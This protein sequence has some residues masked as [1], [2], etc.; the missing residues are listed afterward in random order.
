[1]AKRT[2]DLPLLAQADNDDVLNIV[3]VS[4]N[5]SK[6]V[7]ASDVVPDSSITEGKIADGG[8]TPEKRSGG[9]AVGSLTISSTGNISK[10]GL[11]FKPRLVRV[12]Y[13]E[14]HDSRSQLSQG[15]MD[16][17]GN[18]YAHAIYLATGHHRAREYT[19]S[20]VA[21]FSTPGATFTRYLNASFVSMDNDGFTLN[22]STLTSGPYTVRFEAYA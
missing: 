2:T 19:D 3:D 21:N 22:V 5:T 15:A 18:Q 7:R 11:G 14:T 6:Q 13:S 8:V 4:A 17:N 10:T 1:M 16:E 9:F 12:S 20:V